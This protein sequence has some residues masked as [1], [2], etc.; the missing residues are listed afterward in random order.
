MR[1]LRFPA[2]LACSLIATAGAC[3]D[4][5]EDDVEAVVSALEEEN[6]GLDTADEAPDFGVA[7]RFMAAAIEKGTSFSDPLDRDAAVTALRERPDVVR[8]RVAAAWGQLPPDRDAEVAHDWSGRIEVSRGALVVRHRIGFEEATDAIAPRTSPLAVEFDSVTRPFADGLVLEVLADTDLAGVTLS[9]VG[10]DG[11]RFDVLLADLVAG[12]RS[13]A[14]DADGNRMVVTALRRDRD[15]C[16]HGFMRGRWQALR[17]GLG[18]FL[19][20]VTDADGAPIGHLRGIWGQRRSGER[21]FFGKYIASDG[22]FRGIFAGHYRDGNFAGRWLTRAGEF[23]RA[24]GAYRES[25]PGD[26]LGGHFVGRWAETS[27]AADLP[28]SP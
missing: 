7:D 28:E 13:T 15:D 4:S 24:G 11:A 17:L 8:L 1:T 27:C 2:L 19:G 16:D 9:Y 12:P 25:A 22:Q 26:E 14:P 3:T 20:V 5:P 21:V 6:G 23:G 10:D 18:G